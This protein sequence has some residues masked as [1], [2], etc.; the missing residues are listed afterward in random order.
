MIRI[1]EQSQIICSYQGP[2]VGNA[3][4]DGDGAARVITCGVSILDV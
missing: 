3:P 4:I 2:G 1:R